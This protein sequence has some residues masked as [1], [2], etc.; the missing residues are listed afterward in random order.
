MSCQNDAVIMHRI[1]DS[2]CTTHDLRQALSLQYS[3]CVSMQAF[4][5]IIKLL[6]YQQQKDNDIRCTGQSKS[7]NIGSQAGA[8]N[9][10]Y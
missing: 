3:I 2:F 8:I 9:R 4:G 7:W 6:L 5:L 10:L 1:P